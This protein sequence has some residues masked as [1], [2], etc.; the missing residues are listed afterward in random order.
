MSQIDDKIISIL[1]KED[2]L[3]MEEIK[4]RLEKLGSNSNYE[5]LGRA[6]STLVNKKKKIIREEVKDDGPWYFCYKLNKK[7]SEK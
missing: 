4:I 7:N 6:L 1:S 2:G 5:T 3:R